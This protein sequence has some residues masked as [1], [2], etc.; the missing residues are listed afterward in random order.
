[1]KSAKYSVRTALLAIGAGLASLSL[2]VGVV[3]AL[4][5]DRNGPVPFVSGGVGEDELQQIKK[6]APDYS[7]ELLFANKGSPSEYLADVNVQIKNKDGT[8]VLD[9]VSQGPFLLAK[10]SPGKYSIS[11]RYEGIAK[12]QSIQITS[13]KTQRVVFV[14]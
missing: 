11:A 7:L 12:Q 14:W 9:T 10:M 8:L 3:A 6:L 13:A 1:M 5:V 4:E 2:G